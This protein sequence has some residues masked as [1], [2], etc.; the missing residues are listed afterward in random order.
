MGPGLTPRVG[1]SARAS[2]ARPARARGVPHRFVPVP[3]AVFADG[4]LIVDVVMV[5]VVVAVRVFVL[6]RLVFVVMGV[7]FGQVQQHA[8]QHQHA[9]DPHQRSRHSG[10]PA[11]ARA[12]HR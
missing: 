5:A 8:G 6:E 12:R 10:R 1:V 11:P 2:G 3:V 4:H 7:R 9:P